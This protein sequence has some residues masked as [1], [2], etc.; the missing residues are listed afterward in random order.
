MLYRVGGTEDLSVP[1]A[2]LAEARATRYAG[3][4][5][6]DLRLELADGTVEALKVEGSRVWVEKVEAARAEARRG[7]PSLAP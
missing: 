4:F 3:I 7:V 2:R 6:T 1:L 5:A